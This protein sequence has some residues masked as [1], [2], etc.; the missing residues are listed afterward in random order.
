M[1]GWLATSQAF[2]ADVTD[3][4][5]RAKGMGMLGAAFGLGFICGPALGG[6]LA[7]EVDENY[8]LP[9]IIAAIGSAAAFVISAIM[10]REPKRHQ[11]RGGSTLLFLPQLYAIPKLVA[12]VAL[13]FTLFF[14]FSGMEATLAL[15][16]CL[17]YTSPSPRD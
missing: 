14:V 12:I 3:D 7:G 5:N 17:L 10:L 1:N 13:Y 8:Q 4:E 11:A 16:C 2:I 9:M 15:W 6:Y